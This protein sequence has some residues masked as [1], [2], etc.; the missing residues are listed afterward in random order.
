M[1]SSKLL[2]E[3]SY[4]GVSLRHIQNV[5]GCPNNHCKAVI[6]TT[7]HGRFHF[8]HVL[9]QFRATRIKYKQPQSYPGAASPFLL[10][11]LKFSERFRWITDTVEFQVKQPQHQARNFPSVQNK[12][13]R[14]LEFG[15]QNLIQYTQ[16]CYKTL[17]NGKTS[18]ILRL[19]RSLALCNMSRKFTTRFMQ[20]VFMV[21]L[22]TF[23]SPTQ[24][25][26][27]DKLELTWLIAVPTNICT[28][29]FEAFLCLKLLG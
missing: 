28:I 22:Q 17:S 20:D 2:H 12:R 26:F 16:R 5:S 18:E 24:A 25:L 8:R 23:V 6:L 14:A 15:D 13:Y 7:L 3:K 10:R 29:C 9:F 11:C 19:V 4:L 1:Q 27:H 21:M